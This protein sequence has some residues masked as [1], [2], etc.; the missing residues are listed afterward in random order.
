M[1]TILT[2][3]Q[4][5][6]LDHVRVFRMTTPDMVKK[7]FYPEETENAV[8]S[9]LRRLR[10]SGHIRSAP[11]FR[12][13]HYYYL[14]P[15]AARKLY[16]DDPR[17]VGPHSPMAIAETYGML[18]FCCDGPI[19]FHKFTRKEFVEEFPELII[20]NVQE[21]NYYMDKDSAG[22][23]L[24]HIYVDRGAKIERIIKRIQTIVGRRLQHPVWHRDILSRENCR[25]AIGVVTFPDR[26]AAV[27]EK[28]LKEELPDVRIRMKVVEELFFLT[29]QKR[30]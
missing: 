27:I 3:K 29:N 7:L 6:V 21:F 14:S 24:G 18:R 15:D 20:K 19:Q 13:N 25:F 30:N 5:Q 22:N 1:K 10:E 2:E 11:L 4:K 8:K 16:D 23:R 28:K 26:K 9:H 12:K 17:T